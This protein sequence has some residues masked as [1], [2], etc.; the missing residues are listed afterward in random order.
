MPWRDTEIDQ[1][2]GRLLQTGVLL[3]GTVVLFGGILYL[4]RHGGEVPDY[5]NFHGVLPA[6]KTGSGVLRGVLAFQARAI[7]QLGVLLMIATPVLRVVFAIAAFAFERDWLYTLI[8]AI[9]LALLTYG[10]FGSR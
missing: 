6:L 8:S 10:I 5:R 7:I 4:L 2:M 3:A 9:V 1:M